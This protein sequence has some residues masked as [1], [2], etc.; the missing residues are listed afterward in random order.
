VS[1][2]QNSNE[3]IKLSQSFMLEEFSENFGTKENVSSI[4]IDLNSSRWNVT[5]IELNFTNI[6]FGKETKKIEDIP[7][8]RESLDNKQHALGVQIII[9]NPT[10]IYGVNL[11]LKNNSDEQTDIY[12]QINGYDDNT[13]A[14]NDTI[15][16][17][18][19]LLN[20]SE[21]QNWYRQIFPS[22]ISLS[23]GNYYLVLNGSNILNDPSRVYNWYNSFE[24]AK[25]PDLNI[26]VY[27]D[28][29]GPDPL[30]WND[31]IKASPFLYKL[32]QKINKSFYPSEMNLII[33]VNNEIHDV[34]DGK[35]IGT[36]NLTLPNLNFF[37]DDNNLH[38]PIK[39]N[40]SSELIFNLSYKIKLKNR[41][42]ADGSVTIKE[43]SNNNEWIIKPS[44]IRT[45]GNYSIKFE[46]PQSWYNR[47]VF[48][49]VSGS[50]SSW[51]NVTENVSIIDN[52][53][54]IPNKTIKD[55]AIWK[56]TANSAK[57]DFSLNVPKTE[58]EPTQELWF[59]VIAP[60]IDGNFTFILI[61]ALGFEQDRKTRSVTSTEIIYN[62]TLSSNPNAGEWIAYIYWNNESDAGI[63]SQIFT[64]TDI[65]ASSN[66]DD[67]GLDNI[68]A[69]GIDPLLIFM[70][71]LISII[72]FVAN[73]IIYQTVK[74]IKR[75]RELCM[76]KLRNKIIDA[77]SLNYIIISN[78]RSGLNVY[79]QF[80]MGK[81][82]DP[83]LI[84]GFLRA[85]QSFG[86]E[87]TGT[88]QQSQTIKLEFQNSKILI[89]EFRN[90]RLILI[91]AENPS[92]DFMNSIKDL[93]YDIDEKYGD[94]IR[95]FNGGS[96][97][98]F[99]DIRK[100]IEKHLNIYFFHPLK[101][102]ESKEVKLNSVEKSMVN[103][104][105][106]IM[107]QNNLDYVFVSF[108]MYEQKYNPKNIQTIY[109]LID[110][111]IFQPNSLNL[112]E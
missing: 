95:D 44:L 98:Q 80:F 9:A 18:P 37:P 97:I 53:I 50:G 2:A 45:S 57:I 85:I 84:S 72:V 35:N 106:E 96:I 62:Y 46:S 51:E 34:I 13:D 99:S 61:N 74:R 4:D 23:K 56:I 40:K 26:S 65:F 36:G 111:K 31:G 83:T 103:K 90:F 109:N 54:F 30:K 52:F 1:Y 33:E 101:L 77:L 58:F 104:A 17:T 60:V 59:S 28:P 108:L 15:Y 105:K 7:D 75:K 92:E 42:F 78:S 73:L 11:Y 6:V 82:I 91:I 12:V 20:I 64:I 3:T 48:R 66:G 21:S 38:I 89:N 32:I 81:Y 10:I 93:S 69:V 22:P 70:V 29:L 39:N 16:G 94:L 55:G 14:P 67:D 47:M 112:N 19:A 79:E 5:D 86:I 41:L 71:V 100:L 88:F 49:D 110:K 43:A 25:N 107:K 76:Q 8:D 68:I 24:N 87:L 63:Q 102:V 27:T